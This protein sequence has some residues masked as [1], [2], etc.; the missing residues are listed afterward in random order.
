[1]HNVVHF[2]VGLRP[3]FVQPNRP[4][5]AFLEFVE[6]ARNIGDSSNRDVLR[7]TG[8]S[9][10]RGTGQSSRAAF[11]DDDPIRAR[12]IGGSNQR[13]QI[14]RVFNAVENDQE[15]VV[16]MPLLQQRI[17][18]GV[19]LAAGN[20]DDALVRVRIGY[21]VKLFTRQET[22]RHSTGATIVNEP[23]HPLI[24]PLACDADV[25]EASRARLECFTHRMNAVDNHHRQQ[26]TTTSDGSALPAR[27]IQTCAAEI[28]VAMS[29]LEHLQRQF[30]YEF[31]ANR[32]EL[33]V[34]SR[35]P[36]PPAKAVQLLAHIVAAQLLWLDRLQ[37]NPQRTAVWPD[38]SLAECG[39]H[40]QT[41]EAEWRSYLAG[42]T[43]DELNARCSYRNSKGEPWESSVVDILNHVPLHSAHHRGQIAIETR[44]AGS[45]PAYTDYIH[46]V[47]SGYLK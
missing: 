4:N 2:V 36:D 12:A 5:V 13:S 6:R 19:L 30:E 25:L 14:M 44:R 32:E 23:L 9:L 37:N 10:H 40:L 26:C 41:S 28:K 1:M 27:R 3:A 45:Q 21:A 7:S 18:V 29:F 42:L 11:R 34:L 22:H 43:D 33:S 24:V 8:G 39:A 15:A 38:F 47:R 46:A 20:G 17:D 35:L 16:A 31:W